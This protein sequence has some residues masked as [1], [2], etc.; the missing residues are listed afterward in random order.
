MFD[1]ISRMVF[2]R[3]LYATCIE[4]SQR[5][6]RQDYRE[7][8]SKVPIAFGLIGGI[9][10]GDLARVTHVFPFRNNL[11]SDA[12]YRSEMDRLLELVGTP[13]LAA[14]DA[15]G[16]VSDPREFRAADEASA[17]AGA[18]IFG[19]Y[20]THK[21][22]WPT[23][24]LRSSCTVLDRELARDTG[25]WMFIVSVV[26]IDEPVLRAFFEGDNAREA[27]IVIQG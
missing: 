5:R 24:P 21:Q 17:A 11:R 27:E 9:V 10:E 26:K 7:G 1:A 18:S 16:W 22:P 8:E 23:D 14:N 12:M 4:H 13:S 15:R 20:H 19:S 25:V 2:P 3:P 6:V